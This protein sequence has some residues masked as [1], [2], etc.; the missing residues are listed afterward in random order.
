[1]TPVFLL[2]GR[3]HHVLAPVFS[4]PL[5]TVISSLES[6]VYQKRQ[7]RDESL[8]RSVLYRAVKIFDVVYRMSFFS[9]VSQIFY[10]SA[11]Q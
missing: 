7:M 1:M 4:Q 2:L 5:Y 8:C 3:L 9:P 11:V 6:L 10:K